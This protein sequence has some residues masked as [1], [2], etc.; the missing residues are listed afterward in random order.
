M[1]QIKP[2][3]EIE[4]G[5]AIE[6]NYNN[7]NYTGAIDDAIFY[8]RDLIREKSNL[9]ND[10]LDLINQAFSENNPKI[11]LNKLR[12]KHD[13]NIQ[14]GMRE[15]LIGIWKLIRNTRSHEKHI[16]TKEDA[17][18]II[19]YINYLSKIIEKAKSSFSVVNFLDEVFDKHFEKTEEYAKL[20]VD[21]IPNKQ[22]EDTIFY[23]YGNIKNKINIVYADY[24]DE[25][26]AYLLDE[27]YRNFQSLKLVFVEIMNR[28]DDSSQKEI[29]I[30]MSLDFKTLNASSELFWKVYLILEQWE[31]LEKRIKLRLTNIIIENFDDYELQEYQNKIFIEGWDYFDDATQVKI[32]DLYIYDSSDYYLEKTKLKYMVNRVPIKIQAPSQIPEIDINKDEIPF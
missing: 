19:L 9:E 26:E 30:K 29:Y 4:L 14:N 24:N 15:S 18:S 8:I 7:K 25:Y 28:L 13:K 20:L 2:L 6:Q 1:Q 21:E 3:L 11:K 22:L 32:K 16:D 10:G 5:E 31:E 12:T 27:N 23:L 17:T